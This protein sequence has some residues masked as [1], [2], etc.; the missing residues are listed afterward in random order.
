MKK[1]PRRQKQWTEDMG[2]TSMGAVLAE[3]G[4]R[5][6]IELL[7]AAGGDLYIAECSLREAYFRTAI[8]PTRTR[9]YQKL[10]QR[11]NY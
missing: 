11:V 9:R 4:L 3:V 5:P 10:Y 7:R 6:A 8:L 2:L 1:R